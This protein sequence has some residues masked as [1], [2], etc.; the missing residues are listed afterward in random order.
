MTQTVSIGKVP[1]G[2]E[3]A[4]FFATPSPG[5]GVS[6]HA[7]ANQR[8]A[9]IIERDD[10]YADWMSALLRREGWEYHRERD[11]HAGLQRLTGPATG[12]YDVVL[13]NTPADPVTGTHSPL[14]AIRASCNAPLI[15]L[16]EEDTSPSDLEEGIEQAVKDADY[17]LTKPF[18]PR[19]FR[20]AVRA[21]AR[22]GRADV[23]AH[24][25]T[26]VRVGGLIMSFGRL[27]VAVDGRRV[28]L[29][30]REFALLHLLIANPGTVYTRDELARLAWGWREHSESRAVD[31][32][33]QR[34]RQKIELDPKH[35]Q[36]LR[37]E[38]GTGYFF[39]APE[40]S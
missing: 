3:E 39:S 32:T 16:C 8:R 28:E 15:A 29:S 7:V 33:I 1:A 20:A 23:N 34:I 4:R 10:D 18:S 9:L 11:T 19:R 6:Q 26:E 30:P 2:A 27:E 38:R 21:V 31:N 22:R 12:A 24:L 5:G 35:P 40:T 14:S 37:T 13:I 25:P 36:F 17:N